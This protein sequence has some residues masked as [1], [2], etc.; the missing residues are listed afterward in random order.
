MP[1]SD[2]D[3]VRSTIGQ[4]TNLYT[5]VQLS[6]YVSTI[7]NRG[8]N[9]LTLLDRIVRKD[10]KIVLRMNLGLYGAADIKNSGVFVRYVYGCQWWAPF[11]NFG[12]LE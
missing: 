11:M 4:G 5:P 9:Y 8:T 6:R 7:A 1:C 12:D 2:K 10:G 3:T